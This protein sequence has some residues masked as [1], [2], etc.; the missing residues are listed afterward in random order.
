MIIHSDYQLVQD[1][2]SFFIN[3]GMGFEPEDPDDEAFRV[4]TPKCWDETF[5]Q[6]VDIESYSILHI[7]V[8]RIEHGCYNAVT[9]YGKVWKLFK[10]PKGDFDG[11]YFTDR[12]KVYFGIK[13]GFGKEC[14]QSDT[15]PIMFLFPKGLEVDYNKILI[16]FR[17]NKVDSSNSEEAK[18]SMR[19]LAESIPGSIALIYGWGS[20]GWLTIYGEKAGSIFVH[21]D[22]ARWPAYNPELIFR[23]NMG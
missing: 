21:E 13:R 17:D 9:D 10:I 11:S 14:F 5:L 23:R 7:C 18:R 2:H 15:S 8:E 1:N 19:E 22:L 16:Q 4:G 3:G 20:G 12:G 6:R